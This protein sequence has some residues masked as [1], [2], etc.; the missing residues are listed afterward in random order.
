[1]GIMQLILLERTRNEYIIEYKC[2]RQKVSLETL[3]RLI[4]ITNSKE[5]NC[6]IAKGKIS[7]KAGYGRLSKSDSTKEDTKYT[8]VNDLVVGGVS[9]KL[10]IQDNKNQKYLLKFGKMKDNIIVRDYISEYIACRVASLLGYSVQE[11]KLFKFHNKECVMIKMFDYMPITYSGLGYSTIDGEV[12]HKNDI[13]YNLSWLLNLKMSPNKFAIT[14]KQYRKWVWRVFLLDMFI[15]NYDRH[16]G[17]WGFRV[18]NNKKIPSPLFDMGASL[19]IRDMD[20]IIYLTDNDIK[21]EINNRIRSAVL[22]NGKKRGYFYILNSIMEKQDK[23]SLF[24][25]NEVKALINKI[26]NQWSN[27]EQ[28]IRT[29]EQ[30]NIKYSA[31][32]K[33][34]EKML[35]IKVELLRKWVTKW[36]C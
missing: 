25:L 12:L 29:V 16:E 7:L 1:V 14:Q 36:N 21:N 5:R 8:I 26:D 4:D 3:K 22:F 32:T 6:K 20:K 19:F 31:Y 10:I 23:E 2:K 18:I 11:V 28:V 24:V 13:R 27:I 30:F 35:K 34:I 17:N 9:N 33:F 15:G